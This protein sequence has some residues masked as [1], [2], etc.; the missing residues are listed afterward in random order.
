MTLETQINLSEQALV[1]QYKLYVEMA[2]RISARRADTNKF[3]ISLLTAL[4]VILSIVVDKNILSTI[5]GFVFIAIAILGVALC[6]VWIVNIRS[7]SQL[8]TGKFKVIHDMEKQLPYPCYDRE[9]EILGK[10]ADRRKYFQL[11]RIEQYVPLLLAI[12][13]LLLFIFS[14]YTLVHH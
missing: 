9:W 2:D 1:E 14:L 12:P 11:T 8:N 13:Y 3:Y 4:L 10:G 5:Q 6:F 7:Y